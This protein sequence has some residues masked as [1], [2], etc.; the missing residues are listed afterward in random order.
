MDSARVSTISRRQ[1]TRELFGI[2]HA[3]VYV[4]VKLSFKSSPLHI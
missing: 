1:A 2:K 3:C 4:L